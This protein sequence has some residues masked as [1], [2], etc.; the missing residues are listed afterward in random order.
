MQ[1]L[2]ASQQPGQHSDEDAAV[3]ATTGTPPPWEHTILA[4]SVF[5]VAT[6]VLLLLAAP[7]IGG[8]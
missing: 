4:V 7:G 8:S 3:S 6:V 1:A 5:T 2:S